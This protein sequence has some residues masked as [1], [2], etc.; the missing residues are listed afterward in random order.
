M[1]GVQC[2]ELFGGIALKNHAFF[3]MTPKHKFSFSTVLFLQHPEEQHSNNCS[4]HRNKTKNVFHLL[5]FF[6]EALFLILFKPP[7]FHTQVASQL[8]LDSSSW[9]HPST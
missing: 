3:S 6:D 5:S 1:K 2:Y 9:C 4:F 8:C 7:S